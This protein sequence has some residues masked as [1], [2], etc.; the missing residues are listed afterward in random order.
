VVIDASYSISTAKG[1]Q[2]LDMKDQNQLV[3]E[4][5]NGHWMFLS[6]M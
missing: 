2:R 4:N 3:L 1:P 6:G 5:D